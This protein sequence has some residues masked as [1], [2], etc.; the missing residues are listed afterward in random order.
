LD[1]RILK[2]KNQFPQDTTNFLILNNTNIVY[3]TEFNG[4]TAL[5][6]PQYGENTLYVSETN[7][8]QAKHEVKNT[9][10]K[11]ISRGENLFQKICQDVKISVKTK[12]SID[13]ISIENWKNL[14][15]I[16]GDENSLVAA[17][18]IVMGLRAVK[19]TDEIELIRKACRIADAGINTAYE[20]VKPGVNEQEIIAEIEYT[21]RKQGSSGTAFDT[22]VTSGT[23][24]A[25][26]HGTYR[27]RTIKEGDLVIIDLGATVGFYRSD[28]TR[29]IVAGKI[30]SNQ[31]EVYKTVKTAQDLATKTIMAG[32]KAAEVDAAARTF[33]NKTRFRDC[34]VH[35]LGHGVGLDIH[36]APTLS[37]DSKDVL[38]TGNVITV[39]PGIYIVC[40][41]GIRIEDTILVTKDGTEKLTNATISPSI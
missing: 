4:A 28:I 8:E 12:L 18:N 32:A 20:I 13:S 17:G 41:G 16:T 7:F 38:N 35:N 14:T 33:I 23:N 19:T 25:F 6:V 10:I 24:S 22:I 2:L 37:P 26:P 15:K 34:F 27:K 30:N 1:N 5:L 21:M 36:E 31:Q 40:F 11:K 39:E 3:F 29:T 9:I